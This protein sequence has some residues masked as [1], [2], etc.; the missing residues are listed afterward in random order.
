MNPIYRSIWSGALNTWIAVSELTKGKSKNASNRHGKLCAMT[1]RLLKNAHCL[2]TGLLVCSANSWALPTG[3]Q[4]VAGQADVSTPNAGQMQINQAS[5]KAAI[6]WQGFSINPNEAVNIQQPNAQAALLN[7]VVGQDASQI[8]GQLNANGQVYL[9]NPNGVLFSKTAQVDVGGLIATTHEI[10]NQDFIN[11]NNHFTQN[12][13]TGLVENHGTINVKDGGVVAL[14][15]EKVTNTG[16]INTLK[17]T[18]ALAAGKTVDLDFQGDGLVAVKVTEAALNAQINNQGAIQADGRRVVMSTKAAN[19]LLDT[20]INQNGIVKARGLIERNGEIVL[21]GGD[22][23]AVKV[24]GTLSTDGQNTGGAIKVTGKTV[25]LNNS[26]TV[27]ASGE[28]G[29]GVINI[30]NQQTTGETHIAENASVNAIALNHGNAGVINVLANMNN[31][32]VNVAGKLNATAPNT[33]NGGKIE[34][35]AAHVNIA[36]SAKISTQAKHG[37]NGT[38]FIDPYDFTIAAIGGDITGTALSAALTNGNVKIQT[39]AASVTCTGAVCGAGNSAGNGDI[40]VNDVITWAANNL[41]L[42]AYRNINIDS[43]LNGSGTAQLAFEYGQGALAAGNT[44]DYV[45]QAAVNL[46]AGN[47]FST[48]LGSDGAVTNYTVITDLGV[49]NDTT[50]TSLQGIQNNLTGNYALGSNIDA[51]PAQNWASATGTGFEPIGTNY[52]SNFTGQFHGLGHTISNLTINSARTLLGSVGLFGWSGGLLRDVGLINTSVASSVSYMGMGALGT[53][54]LVGNNFGTINNA[55][56]TGSVTGNYG[57]GGL[58]GSNHGTINNASVTGSV[59]G[60]I[61]VGGLAGSSYGIINNVHSTGNVSG[62]SAVGG[63]VG[64]SYGT[65][66][67]VHATGN[68]SGSGSVGGLVGYN[69]GLGNTI[70]NAYATG[71]V[72]G[73]NSVGGLVGSNSSTINNAYAMGDVSGSDSV[74]GLMGY[75]QNGIINNTY[76]T[77]SVSGNYF[78]GGLVGYSQNST[79]NNAYTTGN[80]TGNSD[81]GGLV[82]GN[83]NGTGTINNAYATGDVSG[84]YNVGGLVGRSDDTINNAYATGDVSGNYNVGGLVGGNRG[85]INNTYATGNVN[86]N[87]GVGGLVGMGTQSGY[88]E[89]G[90]INNSHYNIDQVLINGSHFVTQGG[91]YDAQYQDWMSHNKTLNISDYA[92]T[93]PLDTNTSHYSI[94]NLQSLRDLLGFTDNPTYKFRLNTDIDLAAASGLF[95]PD[96]AGE[97]DGENQILSNLTIN[98]PFTS[99]LGMFG[100]VR[101]TGAVKNV[102]LTNVKITGGDYVGGLIGLNIGDIN[103]AYATG[104]VIG[105]DIIGGLIGSNYYSAIH[106]NTS[107]ATDYYYGTI[108][109]AY[110]T[111]R[112]SGTNSVGGLVGSNSSTINNAYATGSVSGTNSVGGLV[113]S[114][115]STINNAYATGSVTGTNFVGGLVGSNSSNINNAYATGSVTGNRDVGGLVGYNGGISHWLSPRSGGTINNAFWNTETTGKD[116]NSGIGSNIGTLNNISG[117][118]TAEMMQ[119]ATFSNAGWDIANTAGSSAIWRIYEGQT[120]PLLRS[121]LVPLTVDA[122]ISEFY[123]GL[124]HNSLNNAN[125]SIANAVSSGHFFYTPNPF[126]NAINAGSYALTGTLYSDQQG[127]DISYVNSVLTINKANLLITANDANKVYDGLGYS[128]G[129]GVRYTG[130][131]NGE[132]N[133]VLFGNLNY[134]GNSQG[135]INVGSYWITPSGLSADNYQ[136]SYGD[137][138]LTIDPAP[139]IDGKQPELL[140]KKQPAPAAIRYNLEDQRVPLQV[141]TTFWGNQKTPPIKQD[142]LEATI[143]IEKGGIKLPAD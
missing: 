90:T 50:T 25:Q 83:N 23:G 19:Q 91:L 14:I 77:G 113:G 143:V 106:S 104:S 35:S 38:W 28:A 137:G 59:S 96:L 86:G 126:G 51:T 74:G 140:D 76:A 36:D 123:N 131:V 88:S 67:N 95:I 122:N 63:L 75:S 42:S 15:G 11:G 103:N 47:N 97:F 22:N 108:S 71:S 115:S 81:V 119:L 20:V 133:A 60:S 54:A 89:G 132:T 48:R 100:M 124:I 135:A 21:D 52:D 118:T 31:G 70:S 7:R 4:V 128:G 138:Q 10:S 17:G 134:G 45:V 26:A 32:T 34:T 80:I 117:K 68:V 46:P 43:N 110:A 37:N 73:F 116:S 94:N 114:N 78:V 85:T 105:N 136:I 5:Q 139:L 39:G 62:T 30:G 107:L 93:L 102:G 79:I 130:F 92:A 65:I 87:Y 29:G 56:A 82:G 127:Y 8:Q 2:A 69:S 111:S 18:T 41:T 24:S 33:G 120:M 66:S 58:V 72:S 125:F 9:V 49:V 101:E 109:N 57:V 84:N 99:P 64:S 44:S 61:E 1:T 12:G 6:N 141:A 13:A 16:T 3:E 40:F 27:T 121:W 129:N 53:G 142:D 55:Y 98:Q 112:V